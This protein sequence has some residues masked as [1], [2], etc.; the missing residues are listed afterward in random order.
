MVM[1]LR[2]KFQVSTIIVTSFRQGGNFTLPPASKRTPKE[3]N[4][5]RL[6]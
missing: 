6:T 4:Q 2:T 1:Y 3:P 5:I